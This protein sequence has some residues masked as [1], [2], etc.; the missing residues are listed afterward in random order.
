MTHKK[1]LT[2]KE[3][4]PYIVK[5][6]KGSIGNYGRFNIVKQTRAISTFEHW[7]NVV[8]CQHPFILS[9]TL[10]NKLKIIESKLG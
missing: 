2:I 5:L 9:Y 8:R 3:K 1:R 4:F 10:K 7:P 6:P